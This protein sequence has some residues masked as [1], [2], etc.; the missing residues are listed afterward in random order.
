MCVVCWYALAYRCSTRLS[1]V[2]THHLPRVIT[3]ARVPCVSCI[4]ALAHKFIDSNMQNILLAR[5]GG[6][7]KSFSQTPSPP[8]HHRIF[9]HMA[10]ICGV[11]QASSGLACT[12]GRNHCPK[13]LQSDTLRLLMF[14]HKKVELDMQVGSLLD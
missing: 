5:L 8:A 3:W 9:Q 14:K 2:M 6:G 12:G 7:R 4:M 1:T 11:P 10:R 13:D